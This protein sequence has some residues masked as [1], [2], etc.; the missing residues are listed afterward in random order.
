MLDV[1]NRPEKIYQPF[2]RAFAFLVR[3]NTARLRRKLNEKFTLN[4]LITRKI[5]SDP[6]R[7]ELSF[8]EFRNQNR[9]FIPILVSDVSISVRN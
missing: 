2:T 7:F 3:G 5:K 9:H 1:E 6:M 8:F 4:A